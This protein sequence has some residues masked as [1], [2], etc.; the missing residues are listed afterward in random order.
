MSKEIDV[1]SSRCNSEPLSKEV[2]SELVTRIC[3]KLDEVD[4][5]GSDNLRSKRKELLKKAEAIDGGS[6]LIGFLGPSS[7]TS[8]HGPLLH[9]MQSGSA[10]RGK[11]EHLFCF[12]CTTMQLARVSG[13]NSRTKKLNIKYHHVKY[14]GLMQS[15]DLL[16]GNSLFIGVVH[17]ERSRF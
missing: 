11:H 9:G 5:R 15:T 2:I 6:W 1:L 12:H 13:S 17:L 14:R 8:G 10:K 7:Q 3:C 4:T 16:I